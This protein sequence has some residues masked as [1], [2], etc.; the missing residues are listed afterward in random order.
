M[1]LNTSNQLRQIALAI[2]KRPDAAAQISGSPEYPN[3]SGGVYFHSL[4][5]GV[6]V[7]ADITGLPAGSRACGQP[8]FAF[9]IHEGSFCAGNEK[10][11]FMQAMSHFNPADCKHPYHAG[12]MPPLFGCG[13]YAYLSFVTDRFILNQVMGKAVIIHG[14][15]DDFTTQPSGNSGNRIACGIIKKIN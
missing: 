15:P 9:H 1:I 2:Q 8:V 10:D 13:G 5:F 3:I 11:P 4:R 7:T 12:D 6:L 14:S